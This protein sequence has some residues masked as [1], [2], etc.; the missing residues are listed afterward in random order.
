MKNYRKL[1]LQKAEVKFKTVTLSVI[2]ETTEHVVQFL[3]SAVN[4]GIA[5]FEKTQ[6][7]LY[8]DNA[9]VFWHIGKIYRLKEESPKRFLSQILNYEPYQPELLQ[10][11]RIRPEEINSENKKL[12]VICYNSFRRKAVLTTEDIFLVLEQHG[13]VYNSYILKIL[14]NGH[15]YVVFLN[16]ESSLKPL[17]FFERIQ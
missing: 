14:F 2:N 17:K 12:E 8:R 16:R 15:K 13:P 11:F 10:D 7:I 1:F 6:E 3:S 5:G 4:L 9:P